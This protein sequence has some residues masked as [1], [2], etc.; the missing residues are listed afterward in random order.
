MDIRLV[1]GIS[2]D[3][4]KNR[5][6]ANM[7]D[8]M[9]VL[10][11]YYADTKLTELKWLSYSI[12]IK[13]EGASDALAAKC[14][15][16]LLRDKLVISKKGKPHEEA[17][18]QD[19]APLIAKSSVD[20]KDGLLLIDCLLSA[21]PS[22]FLNPEYLVK[23]LKSECGILSSPDLTQEYYSILRIAGYNADMSDFR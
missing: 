10:D 9:Q 7:T 17:K 8:E 21:S 11:A 2:P 6:N 15:D 5:L 16:V 20:F 18:E 14:R 19:I 22:E 23:A 3:E 1:E 13:T 12:A 4:V